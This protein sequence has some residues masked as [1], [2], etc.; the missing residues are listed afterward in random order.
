[1]NV[2][3]NDSKYL[4]ALKVAK[5]ILENYPDDDDEFHLVCE[6]LLEA[7]REAQYLANLPESMR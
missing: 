7:E 6:A 2:N 4:D 1:M 3:Y 5:Q